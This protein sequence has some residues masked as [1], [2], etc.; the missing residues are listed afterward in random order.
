IG[1]CL[2]RRYW[3]QSFGTETAKGLVNFG[4]NSLGLHRIFTTCIP[5]NTASA[6]VLEKTGMQLEG[7]PR[8]HR[9]VKGKWRNSLVY[10]IHDQE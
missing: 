7:H 2:R 8:Q 6:N 5:A 1:Y 3:R 4:F 9:R 10:A